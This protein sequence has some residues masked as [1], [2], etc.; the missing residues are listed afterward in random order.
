VGVLAG[1]GVEI[2]FL[3]YEGVCDWNHCGGIL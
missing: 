2:F 3:V 1:G